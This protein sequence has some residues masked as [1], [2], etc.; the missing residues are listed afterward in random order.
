[1]MP[2]RRPSRRTNNHLVRTRN[3]KVMLLCADWKV[4]VK[5]LEQ[6]RAEVL[7]KAEERLIH[8]P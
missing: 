3:P 1:M 5:S 8:S 6:I 2:P 4:P 7:A